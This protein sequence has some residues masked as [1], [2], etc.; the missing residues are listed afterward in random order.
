MC[1]VKNI[2]QI[3]FILGSHDIAKNI[4]CQYR[5]M[6]I[7]LPKTFKNCEN[8]LLEKNSKSCFS[9]FCFLSPVS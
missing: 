9:F 4:S 2:S 6:A 8:A 3:P 7:A 5:V 1:T